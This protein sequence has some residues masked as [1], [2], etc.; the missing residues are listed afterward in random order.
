VAAP[1][2]PLTDARCRAWTDMLALGR[3]PGPMQAGADDLAVMP[4]TSGTTGAPK[5]CMHTHRSVMATA[6]HGVVWFGV[7]QESVFLSVLPLF[8]VTGMAGSMSGPIYAG[9]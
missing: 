1:R 9:A 5:G 6:V 2:R 7:T 8:H 3:R 4:Y